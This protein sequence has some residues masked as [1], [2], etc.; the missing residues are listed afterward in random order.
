VYTP[1]KYRI[2]T[3]T[4]V[5]VLDGDYHRGHTVPRGAIVTVDRTTFGTTKLVQIT[6]DGKK[7]M[8]FLEDLR[9]RGERIDDRMSA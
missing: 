5:L 1:G 7:A 2:N 3:A 9:S 6:W 8:M 4:L